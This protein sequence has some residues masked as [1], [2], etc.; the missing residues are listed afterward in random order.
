M[1]MVT[2]TTGS[3][4]STYSFTM[5]IWNSSTPTPGLPS[6]STEEFCGI[7]VLNMAHTSGVRDTQPPSGRFSILNAWHSVNGLIP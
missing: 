7:L 6:T 1:S 5:P 2:K 4:A 3:P